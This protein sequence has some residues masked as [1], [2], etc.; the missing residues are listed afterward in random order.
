MFEKFTIDRFDRDIS[1]ADFSPE[2]TVG[3]SKKDAKKKYRLLKDDFRELQELLYASKKYSLLIVLQGIDC[4][5]KDGTVKKLLSKINPNGFRVESFKQPT[6]LEL[7]HDYLWRV[8]QK[9]P[10]DGDIVVFNRSY[11]EDILVTRVH[12]MIDDETAYRRFEEIR[13]FEKYLISNDTI[14]L[15]FFLHIS[16]EFQREKLQERLEEKDK[17]WK[18][19]ESDLTERAHWDCYQQ[20][21]SDMIGHCSTDYAPWHIIP[22]NNRWFRDYLILNIVVNALKK[23]PLEFPEIETNVQRLIEEV[24][25]M[26]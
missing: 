14:V 19:S 1:T 23:L 26:P 13:G 17:N 22:S 12:E 10:K 24:R 18:F 7:G 5:G 16:P 2:D 11:Y 6:P 21:Y 20:Y 9:T 3:L 25:T 4:S 15:K 8:H